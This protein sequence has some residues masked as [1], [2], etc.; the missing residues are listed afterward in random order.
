M[1]LQ[2][3]DN[4]RLRQAM[5][6]PRPFL[7]GP[8]SQ[9]HAASL[10]AIV[11]LLR[12][13]ACLLHVDGHADRRSLRLYLHQGIADVNVGSEHAAAPDAGGIDGI[14]S[15]LANFLDVMA[16][17]GDR[18]AR[19]IGLDF[20]LIAGGESRYARMDIDLSRGRGVERQA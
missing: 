17:A 12:R 15:G 3:L 10:S 13:R 6:A 19:R 18:D 7:A 20:Y 9:D 5:I 16:G 1:I 4:K 11:G 8:T 2:V 14:G